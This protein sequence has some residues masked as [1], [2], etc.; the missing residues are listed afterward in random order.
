M[1]PPPGTPPVQP[2]TTEEFSL[3]KIQPGQTTIARL[4][5]MLG[6]PDEVETVDGYT[7]HT[8]QTPPGYARLEFGM[9]E[10]RVHSIFAA[11]TEPR[12]RGEMEAQLGLTEGDPARVYD[13]HGGVI[14]TVYPE[15]GVLLVRV[16]GPANQ[17]AIESV[18]IQ[19][20]AAEAYYLRSLDRPA[21]QVEAQVADLREALRLDPT[22]GESWWRQAKLLDRI[23]AS[24]EA[25]AAAEKAVA[26]P[27]ARP[28]FHLTKAVLAAHRGKY[29]ASL[30]E[31]R[32]IA[33]DK[34]VEPYV[35]AQ[36]YC[37]LGDLLQSGGD[38]KNRQALEYHTQ[39]I[40]LAAELMNSPEMIPRRAAKQVL[41]DA[42]L[43]LA[44]DIA[45][46]EWQQ[47]EVTVPKW[48]E[49]AE[50]YIQDLIANEG[51]S[52]QL[53]FQRLRKG[54]AANSYFNTQWSASDAAEEI[55]AIGRH[56]VEQ[57]DDRLFQRIV[58]WEVGQSMIQAFFIEHG[59]Q[60]Y[61]EALALAEGAHR[62]QAAGGVDR[63]LSLAETLMLGNLYFRTGT[64][65]AV[66][67][68]DH[69][70]AVDWY[71][72]AEPLLNSAEVAH[73]MHERRGES[74]VSMDVSYWE[75]GKQ[76]ARLR[77]TEQG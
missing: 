58:E 34:S 62:Y 6:S 26:T 14:G 17:T 69:A 41:V 37:H 15:Q 10:D 2:P 59:R 68:Q 43:G 32:R 53:N 73:M 1:A 9:E 7:V 40:Q 4:Q 57:S 66:D 56:L 25:F 24:D 67:Q 76:E 13:D 5:A 51:G 74:L 63:D 28:E 27:D 33:E 42:H 54:L 77:L 61:E 60:H 36:A 38:E 50:A 12:P 20:P 8:Y 21:D 22:Y 64:I 70:T 72:R 31:I 46:G 45:A 71:E 52:E 44:I 75:D 48:L 29:T 65:F 35:R 30:T 55:Q 18:I 47:K 39:A 19:A 11:L 49:R 3:Q 16:E 23:G